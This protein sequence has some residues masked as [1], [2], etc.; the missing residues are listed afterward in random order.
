METWFILRN[1]S[2]FFPPSSVWTGAS[3]MHSLYIKYFDVSEAN[4]ASPVP[5]VVTA[6][7]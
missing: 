4:L 1:L 5:T 6:T 7:P 2:D 3:L